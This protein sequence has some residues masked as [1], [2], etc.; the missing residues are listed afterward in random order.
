MIKQADHF[1]P[2]WTDSKQ[3]KSSSLILY[4][5]WICCRK[6]ARK[7]VCTWWSKQEQQKELLHQILQA[8]Y[9]RLIKLRL[10]QWFMTMNTNETETPQ[11]G[12]LNYYFFFLDICL[13]RTKNK[14]KNA[15]KRCIWNIHFT[16]LYAEILSWQRLLLRGFNCTFTST[17]EEHIFPLQQIT[18]FPNH[19]QIY[20]HRPH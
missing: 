18:S 10:V 13:R 6:T 9:C 2:Q 7:K 17:P 3:N 15:Q 11:A 19:M 14:Q 8:Q 12:T 1:P 5:F 16:L 4:W 20:L